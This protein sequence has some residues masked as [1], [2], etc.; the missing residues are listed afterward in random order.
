M[1]IKLEFQCQSFAESALKKFYLGM[2]VA[3]IGIKH[4]SGIDILSSNSD[5]VCSN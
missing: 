2:W 4:G 3:V 5:L 1:W